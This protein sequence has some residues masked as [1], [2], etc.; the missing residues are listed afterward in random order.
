MG[1][2]QFGLKSECPGL[3]LQSTFTVLVNSLCLSL[4][5]TQVMFSPV[6]L[7]DLG[8][9]HLARWFFQYTFAATTA[10]IVSGAVAERCSLTAYFTYSFMLTGAPVFWIVYQNG[11]LKALV[12]YHRRDSQVTRRK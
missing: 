8:N 4:L 12:C 5:H 7:A 6:P 2:T 3:V 9:E 10:T 1:Y 11:L